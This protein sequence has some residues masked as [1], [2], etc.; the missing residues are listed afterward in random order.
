MSKIFLSKNFLSNFF[1]PKKKATYFFSVAE[2]FHGL[3]R[4]RYVLCT[5]KSR[6]LQKI[7]FRNKTSMA[8]NF[9]YES[10]TWK[11]IR[12][13]KIWTAKQ[14][15]KKKFYEKS[16]EKHRAIV[17]NEWCKALDSWATRSRSLKTNFSNF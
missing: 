10:T 13:W 15:E 4:K 8:L 9:L 14:K 11:I 5:W 1:Y 16:F 3:C 17:E 7:Q 12:F 2:R 6:R